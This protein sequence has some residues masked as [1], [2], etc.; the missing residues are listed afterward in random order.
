MYTN[1]II[2]ENF[3]VLQAK[4]QEYLAEKYYCLGPH[5]VS[6]VQ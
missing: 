5:L 6:S 3:E 2:C 4:E 1:A